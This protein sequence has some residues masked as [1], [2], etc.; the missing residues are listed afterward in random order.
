MFL[1]TILLRNFKNFE[2][3]ELGFSPKLNAFVGPNGIG[4]TNIL[5][6]VHYLALAKSYLNYSD[7]QNIRFGEDFL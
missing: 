7:A 1:K 5:D 2:E 3:L 4:K 6:A